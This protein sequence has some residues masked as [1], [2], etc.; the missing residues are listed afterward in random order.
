MKSIRSMPRLIPG[1]VTH[2]RMRLPPAGSWTL[3]H[4]LFDVA[5]RVISTHCAG[6]RYAANAALFSGRG[7]LL[8]SL[9]D[10]KSSVVS[11]R[12]MSRIT[13]VDSPRKDFKLVS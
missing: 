5:A 11:K 13:D 7:W 3:N 1:G 10:D 8:G 12:M 4:S 9:V 6:R 2:G